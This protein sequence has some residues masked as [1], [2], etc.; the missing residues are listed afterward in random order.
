MSST[1]PCGDLKAPLVVLHLQI[2][3]HVVVMEEFVLN[4]V[5]SPLSELVLLV[6]VLV[7]LSKILVQYVAVKVGFKR[8]KIHN[9]SFII[10]RTRHETTPLGQ[11]SPN[12]A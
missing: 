3:L 10:T 9:E 8:K 11:I 2:V 1:Q 4:K 5:F 6:K 7:K 12:R